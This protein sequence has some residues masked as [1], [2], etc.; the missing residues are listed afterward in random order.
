MGNCER[1]QVQRFIGG[2]EFTMALAKFAFAEHGSTMPGKFYRLYAFG[3]G[4]QGTRPV[5][6]VLWFISHV[7]L[8]WARVVPQMC[9]SLRS[10]PWRPTVVRL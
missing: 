4:S 1:E 6:L 5:F 10:T 9:F 3:A 8:I 7:V 2:L